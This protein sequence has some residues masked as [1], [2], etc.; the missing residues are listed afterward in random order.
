MAGRVI[1]RGEIWMLD[2]GFERIPAIPLQ[3]VIDSI[4]FSMS[5]L[6]KAQILTALSSLDERL[7]AR[8]VMGGLCI[9]RGTAM[10]LVFDARGSTR[11]VDGIFVPKSE[12]ADGARMVAEALGLLETWLNDGVKGFVSTNGELT[13]EG[14]P[15]FKH[16][17]FLRPTSEYLLAM[18]CIAARA[19][20]VD[21][22]G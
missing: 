15:R 11:E 18:K 7:E 10:G 12:L 16:L 21:E 2:L 17:R 1:Q 9:F 14:P 19:S 8:A 3:T 6:T 22:R 4:F 13:D 5:V 20:D